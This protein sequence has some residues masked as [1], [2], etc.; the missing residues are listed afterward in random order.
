LRIVSL[1]NGKLGGHV[2]VTGNHKAPATVR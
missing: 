2:D 1:L